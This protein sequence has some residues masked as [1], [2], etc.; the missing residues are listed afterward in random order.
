VNCLYGKHF[1]HLVPE[2][3]DHLDRD[4]ARLRLLERAR[5][6][7]VETRPGFLVDLSFQRRLQRLV[8]VVGAEEIG[9]ANEEALAV[10]IG[11]NEPSGNVVET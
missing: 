10:V 9:V 11:V 1:H 4:P 3:I 6:V 8:G 5:R 7:G 2:V